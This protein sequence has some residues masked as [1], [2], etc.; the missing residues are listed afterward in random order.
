[1]E[2]FRWTAAPPPVVS[3]AASLPVGTRAGLVDRSSLVEIQV[4]TLLSSGIALSNLVLPRR[5]LYFPPNLKC[6][7]TVVVPVPLESWY[8]RFTVRDRSRE[9]YCREGFARKLARAGFYLAGAYTLSR[10]W[11]WRLQPP[12]IQG[13]PKVR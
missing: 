5:A 7:C 2:H 9:S 1:M 4:I 12:Q 10:L 11:C 3:F 6:G 8:S 13:G